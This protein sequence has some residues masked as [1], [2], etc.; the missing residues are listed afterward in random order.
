MDFSGFCVIYLEPEAEENDLEAD[1]GTKL[2]HL[3]S[4]NPYIT[5]SVEYFSGVT[6]IPFAI[7][8]RGLIWVPT[9]LPQSARA[10]R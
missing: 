2:L 6:K 8:H 1:S 7:R 10:R 9:H 5:A 3:I 4:N